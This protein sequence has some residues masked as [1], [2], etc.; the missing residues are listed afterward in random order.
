MWILDGDDWPSP[1]SPGKLL[2]HSHSSLRKQKVLVPPEGN[3]DRKNNFCGT[4]LFAGKIRPLCPV[5]THR[6]PVNAGNA[7]EDTEDESCS[8][9]PQRPI[10]C[11]AFRPALSCAELSVDAPAALLPLLWFQVMLCPLYSRGADLS[12]IIFLTAGI[13]PYDKCISIPGP[14]PGQCR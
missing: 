6:L 7:S 12:S 11:P 2:H 1:S 10:C 3:K 4:T 9:C 8:P 5:P 14:R 13:C